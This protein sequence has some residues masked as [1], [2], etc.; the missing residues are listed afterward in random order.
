MV[1]HAAQRSSIALKLKQNSQPYCVTGRVCV[2]LC[3][4]PFVL[5]TASKNNNGKFN[6]KA[7]GQDG[8]PF[9]KARVEQCYR[10]TPA[11]M[12]E[13]TGG[14]NKGS[15]VSITQRLS[16]GLLT[17]TLQKTSYFLCFMMNWWISKY[18]ILLGLV[19]HSFWEISF[20]N[21]CSVVD[22]K[23]GFFNSETRL[24][25]Q[26]WRY[27][28]DFESIQLKKIPPHAS[29]HSHSPKHMNNL[30]DLAIAQPGRRFR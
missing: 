30:L 12:A 22:L 6:F 3:Q 24:V 25:R 8:C 21:L 29:L 20:D 1:S 19:N 27:Q 17:F 9:E 7:A 2:S 15:V 26:I 4:R 5:D 16:S 10:M 14:K 18:W 13:R 23:V 28:P 11:W